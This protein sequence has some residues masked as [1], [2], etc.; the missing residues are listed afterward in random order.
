M[1]G[2]AW[3]SVAA[4]SVTCSTLISG[5]SGRV[6]N[7]PSGIAYAGSGSAGSSGARCRKRWSAD[8]GVLWEA[9]HQVTTWHLARVS[10]T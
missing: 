2:P 10:A 1:V 3:R 4:R 6:A 5:P 8:A 9:A 7:G